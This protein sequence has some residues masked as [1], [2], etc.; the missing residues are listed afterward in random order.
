MGTV[1]NFLVHMRT[2]N[3]LGTLMYTVNGIG[4]FH[5][6]EN[7]MRYFKNRISHTISQVNLYNGDTR[8]ASSEYILA[9][10]AQNGAMHRDANYG[11]FKTWQCSIASIIKDGLN[12]NSDIMVTNGCGAWLIMSAHDEYFSCDVLDVLSIHAYGSGDD[13]VSRLEA[14]IKKAKAAGK[15][16]IME[17]W[18]A[19]Y[20]HHLSNECNGGSPLAAST[21]DVNFKK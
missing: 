4:D 5:T 18:G 13:K 8:S 15:M 20:T 19:Y 9:F 17:E 21:R 16:C 6:D 1:S 10:E 14:Y 11:N 3:I 12:E 2:Y 7:A